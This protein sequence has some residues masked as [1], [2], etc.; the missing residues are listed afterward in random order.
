MIDIGRVLSYA[1]SAMSAARRSGA[2]DN[3]SRL[4]YIHSGKGGCNHRGRYIEF[5]AG[6]LYFFPSLA[7]AELSTDANDKIIH[8]Y[9]SFELITPIISSD[10]L[11]F[12]PKGDREAECALHTFLEGGSMQMLP[13][14][15]SG[16]KCKEY[17]DD[18]LSLCKAAIA[19]LTS[20]AAEASDI[21]PIEDK[22]II[23]A[24]NIMHGS[25]SE[26][27]SIESL[28]KKYYIT[29]DAFIRRFRSEIGVTPY[30]YL[31]GLRIRTAYLLRERGESLEK[32]AKATG[33]SDPSSLLHAMKS[34]K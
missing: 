22:I 33:Y 8:T 18:F 7:D 32:I 10:I 24:L 28:A 11:E 29:P 30:A 21:H 23:S 1:T 27:I 3:A 31:K 14:D 6:H 9:A 4:C 5:K 2:Y 16:C 25:L 15:S 19:Y 13:A 20:K 17:T 26:S 34:F 12:N